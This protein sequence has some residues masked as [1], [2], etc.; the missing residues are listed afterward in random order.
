[1][2]EM[3]LQFVATYGWQL[4]LIACSG[5]IVVGVLKFFKV[6]NKID[7]NKRKYVFAG[8]SAGI[9]IIASAIY[10]VIIS[11]FNW[12]GFGVIAGAIYTVNQALY[13]VYENTGLRALVRKLG[14][15]FIHFI[16]GKELE[17]AK[18]DIIDDTAVKENETENVET[19]K[20]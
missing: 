2:E 4:G 6:F 9:S 7:K 19:I 5:I 11:A 10:L 17:K 12:A 16:A 8:I 18:Q 15:L 3:I 13:T 20:A 1:M 14:D